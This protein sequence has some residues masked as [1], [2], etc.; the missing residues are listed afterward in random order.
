MV[1]TEP[2]LSLIQRIQLLIAGSASTEM[3]R[4][5]GWRG[6]IQFY[7]FR[8]P[9]HGIVENYPQGHSQ[10]LKCPRCS[11]AH[12]NIDHSSRF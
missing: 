8:C 5:P 3:R 6:E 10:T 7:A 4:R 12:A 1:E 11:D 2:G 9:V